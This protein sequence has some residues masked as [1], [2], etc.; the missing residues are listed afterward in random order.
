MDTAGRV[1]LVILVS[2]LVLG[3]CGQ[4]RS[5]TVRASAYN[6]TLAQTDGNPNEGAWGDEIRQT[7]SRPVWTAEPR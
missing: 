3:A 7:C 6:S 5:L 4:E 1:T 2:M